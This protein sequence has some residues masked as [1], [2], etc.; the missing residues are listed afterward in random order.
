MGKNK[1]KT[2]RY[3]YGISHCHS[4]YSTGNKTPYDTFKYGRDNG[5][6]FLILTDHNSYISKEL[7]M[8]NRKISRWLATETIRDKFKKNSNVFLPLKGFETKTYLFGYLN[9]INSSTFFTGIVKDLKALV[10][11]MLNNP[12]SIITINHPNKNTNLLDYNE[13]LNKIITSVEVSASSFSDKYVQNNNY[14]YNLLD[15]GW[16]LGAINRNDTP[17]SDFS[18]NQNLTAF[19]ATDL[20]SEN[21][22][23]AFRNR[24]TYSTES[25]SLKMHFTINDIFMGD[26]INDKPSTLQFMIFAEDLNVK[27]IAIEIITNKGLII[28]RIEGLTLNS[29]KYMYNHN[30]EADENW[31]LIKI[32]QEGKKVSISSA[33]FL[34]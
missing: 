5:L 7:L 12:D 17:K 24:K 22:I 14:Y 11:W 21:L 8:N 34:N 4:S 1:E 20:D 2:L 32:Y 16:K 19:L 28:K 25:R 29:I 30:R 33:I 26:E 6:D 23:S 10:L 15:K 18:D 3:Y 13:L 27:I 31:Y 9:I